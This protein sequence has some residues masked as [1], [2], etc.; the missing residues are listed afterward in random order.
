MS[1]PVDPFQLI[2]IQRDGTVATDLIVPH[3]VQET[4]RLTAQYFKGSAYQPPWVG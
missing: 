1:H 3:D 2:Q 4:C